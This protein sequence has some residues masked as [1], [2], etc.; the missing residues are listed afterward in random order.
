MT[1]KIQIGDYVEGIEDTLPKRRTTRGWVD[2]V[3]DSYVCVQV[4][5]DYKGARGTMYALDTVTVL[6][7]KEN[8]YSEEGCVNVS[9]N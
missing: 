2:R 3:F 1:A 4:D 6:P 5:D 8:P 7:Y 9:R